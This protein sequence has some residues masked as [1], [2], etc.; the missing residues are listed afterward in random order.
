MPLSGKD[1]A[2]I[3]ISQHAIKAFIKRFKQPGVLFRL[4]NYT[5]FLIFLKLQLF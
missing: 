5:Y 3:M 1:E 2:K 4:N